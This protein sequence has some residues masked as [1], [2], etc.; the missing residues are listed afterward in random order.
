M[1]NSDFR[2]KPKLKDLD[3]VARAYFEKLLEKDIGA[4]YKMELARLEEVEKTEEEA[5]EQPK[6]VANGAK[7]DHDVDE[8]GRYSQQYVLVSAREYEEEDEEGGNAQ[9]DAGI[10]LALRTKET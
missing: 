8:E 3:P 1:S 6:V 2:G 4:G 9:A 5:E 7:E 10:V